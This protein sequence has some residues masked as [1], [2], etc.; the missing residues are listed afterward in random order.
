MDTL[1]TNA[2]LKQTGSSTLPTWNSGENNVPNVLN[3][4][5]TTTLASVTGVAVPN[6]GEH[7]ATM[8]SGTFTPAETGEYR[9]TVEGDDAV[10]LFINGVLVAHHYGAHGTEALGT[11]TG[12]ITLTAGQAYTFRARQQERGGGDGLRVFWRK[13]SQSGS[14][15]WFQD[16][17]EL[18]GSA[19][20]GHSGT[21]SSLSGTS[22]V[23]GGGGGGGCTVSGCTPGL[24]GSG[25]GGAG[26][27][28]GSTA[29][30][31]APN[32]G[33]AGGGAGADG[34]AGNGGSGI[35]IIRYRVSG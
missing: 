23:Y 15:L 22:T 12:T 9:F 10:D 16:G 3:W 32:T 26:G 11:H 25:G 4:M 17:T 14:S 24:G 27:G 35:V 19:G 5:D 33:G 1:F 34:V 21:T 31:G 29:V 7:F 8:V 13:P 28:H 30:S 2:T 6:S 20:N 18:G